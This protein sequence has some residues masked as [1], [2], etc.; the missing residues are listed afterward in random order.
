MNRFRSISLAVLCAAMA[1]VACESA[2]SANPLSP[3]VAGPIPGVSIS[4]PK[5]LE[6]QQGG[7]VVKNGEPM[8]LLFENAGTSGQ[9]TLFFQLQV[10]V[11]T[12]FDQLVHHAE[13]IEPG[14]NG[15]TSYRMPEELGSGHTYYW[16]L[17][18]ADGA[19]TGPYSATSSFSV[20]DPVV[21]ETPT[22]L[23]PAGSISTNR[24][25]FRVRNGRVSGTSG[26]YYRFELA[27][28]PD[29]ASIVAVVTTTPGSNGETTM[30]LGDLPYGRT[31]YWRVHASDGTTQSEYSSVVSFTTP[32]PPAAPTPIP[33]N[34]GIPTAPPS[35]QP[36]GG[37]AADPPGNQLLPVPSYGE[38]VV[39]DTA[40]RYPG[41]LARA[42]KTNHE[43]LFLLLNALRSHDT[44]WGLNWKRGNA[45]D[46]SSDIVSY[47][48]TNRPD[49]GNGQVYIFDVIGAECEQNNPTFTDQ[50]QGTWAVRDNPACASGT[51]CVRWTIQPYMQAGFPAIIAKP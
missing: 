42:C 36:S 15:R 46:M 44:R 4:A 17:R 5:P 22:P 33:G 37:R 13:R 19:N 16:R 38:S 28:S 50:T 2:K 27:T 48:P 34:P 39:M 30:S 32:P 49:E 45:G 18:A 40:R 6:P 51:Y 11:D 47:N 7:Q 35:V 41:Q 10:A 8:T 9:R 29:P 21:M 14:G 24:P 43:W 3:D 25:T 1:T 12:N 23:E 20:I 31:F 26:A